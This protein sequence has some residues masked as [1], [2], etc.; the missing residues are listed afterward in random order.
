METDNPAIARAGSPGRLALVDDDEAVRVVASFCLRRLG[1]EVEVFADGLDAR[2]WLEANDCRCV[3]TDLRMP[4][5]D[6]VR[7]LQWLHRDRPDT[8]L[9]AISGDDLLA[10]QRLRLAGLPESLSILGKPFSFEQLESL[11]HRFAAQPPVATVA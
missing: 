8:G 5:Y 9:V 6:G 3:L 4:G 10:R 11:A 2:K 7:L 1:W